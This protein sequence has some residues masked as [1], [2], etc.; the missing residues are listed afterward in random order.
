MLS[1][2]SAFMEPW[3]IPSR[4]LPKEIEEDLQA[5][6]PVHKGRPHYLKDIRHIITK[7]EAKAMIGRA[8]NPRDRFVVAFFYLTGCRPV[9]LI[10]VKAKDIVERDGTVAITIFTAKLGQRKGFYIDQRTLEIGKGSSFMQF[11]TDFSRH[12]QPEALLCSISTT[13]L[14]V[15]IYALSL[16]EFCPYHFR[17]SRLTNL[18]RAGMTVDGLMYWKGASSTLSVSNYIAGKPIGGSTVIV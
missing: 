17:H 16:N 12:F 3:K 11:I 6:M 13:R 7:E 4:P 18:A 8:N 9:E 5:D 1:L 2:V 10:Q 15:I 14:R